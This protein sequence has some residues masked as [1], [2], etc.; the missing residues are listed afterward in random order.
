MVRLSSLLT[1]VGLLG[2]PLVAAAYNQTEQNEN[3]TC[4]VGDIPSYLAAEFAS[5]AT[6]N[7][8]DL[9]VLS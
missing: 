7:T 9:H 3:A 2:A 6:R 4:D 5:L 8:N 1:L